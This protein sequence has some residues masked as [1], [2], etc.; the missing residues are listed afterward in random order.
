MRQDSVFQKICHILEKSQ[1][2]M[3]SQLNYALLLF[4]TGKVN[5]WFLPKS[6]VKSKCKCGDVFGFQASDA[7]RFIGQLE[8][9]Q[10]LRRF[11]TIT[12][13][14]CIGRLTFPESGQGSIEEHG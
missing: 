5:K 11:I 6:S 10:G 7:L 9:E 2:D 13:R 4:S 14:G 1:L 3:R 12:S 8:R